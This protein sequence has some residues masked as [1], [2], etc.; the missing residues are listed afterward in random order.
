MQGLFILWMFPEYNKGVQ[1][2]HLK[3]KSNFKSARFHPYTCNYV[4]CIC[5]ASLNKKHWADSE[6]N[7]CRNWLILP[8][9]TVV[10]E[11]CVC[12]RTVV[13]VSAA[14]TMSAS[15]AL[16]ICSSRSFSMGSIPLG[17]L[18]ISE[19]MRC[20]SAPEKSSVT[21]WTR[22]TWDETKTSCSFWLMESPDGWGLP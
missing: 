11:V 4:K 12:A 5:M 6:G 21:H 7:S 19:N 15:P 13:I 2:L 20:S 17:T 1:T 16:M 22:S 9:V 18:S 8:R 14:A 10:A 3:K